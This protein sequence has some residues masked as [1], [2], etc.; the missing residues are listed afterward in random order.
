[1][2]RRD[3]VKAMLAASVSTPAMLG[4]QAAPPAPPPTS[5]APSVPP[6]VPP[7]TAPG[8][9]PWMHGLMEVKPLPMTGLVPD[10]VA[11]TNAYF[12]TDRQIAT[13]RRLSEI[14]LPPIQGY[15]GALDAGTPEFLDF[16]LG[17]S[18]VD[19]QQLYQSGLD[20]LDAEARQHFGLSFAAVE[21][22]QADQLLR[23]W[24]RTWMTDHPPAEP[25]ADFI[26]IAHSDIR[27][28]T[29]NSQAWS[30]AAANEA[31]HRDLNEGLYWYP[32]DPDIHRENAA[33]ECAASTPRIRLREKKH[34]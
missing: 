5:V 14:L 9:V 25:F 31:G 18:P 20:R 33:R 28:A 21:K 11:Q 1:M 16:L 24:L 22:E 34:S 26:N 8:P 17:V 3:F 2:R 6:P 12:F 15:P 13:L 29:I 4:Q 7:P 19:R 27:T 30:E 32:I 23:P 10:A